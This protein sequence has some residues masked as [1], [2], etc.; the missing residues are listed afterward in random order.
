MPGVSSVTAAS[1]A[2]GRPLAARNDVLSVIPAPLPD[3]DIKARIEASDAV[4]VVKLGRHFPRVR[5]LL[6]EMG[7]EGK[8]GYCERVTLGNEKVMP[9][10]EVTETEAPYFSMILIYEG[11]ESWVNNLPQRARS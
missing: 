4:A 5:A 6:R 9:L 10:G 7:L 1:A 2:W 3:E 8:A 11:A